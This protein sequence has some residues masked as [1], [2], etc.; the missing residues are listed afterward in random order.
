MNV[1][2]VKHTKTTKMMKK[3]KTTGLI[4]VEA[5]ISSLTSNFINVISNNMWAV[6]NNVKQMAMFETDRT[7]KR[8]RNKNKI[9][10]NI[11]AK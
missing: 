6:S 3:M 9:I 10:E 11:I 8:A 5:P 2:M 7:W 1:I 4:A